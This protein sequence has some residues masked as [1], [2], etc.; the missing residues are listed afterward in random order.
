MGGAVRFMLWSLYSQ[1]TGTHYKKVFDIWLACPTVGV[2]AAVNQN[3]VPLTSK[4][5][6]NNYTVYYFCA[7]FADVIFTGLS[8]ENCECINYWYD[9]DCLTHRKLGRLKK[10]SASVQ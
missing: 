4:Q 1:R 8:E 6:P 9:F 3:T 2:G 5:K 7:L 10:V